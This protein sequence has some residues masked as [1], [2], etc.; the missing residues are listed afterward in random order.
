MP[1]WIPN[2]QLQIRSHA[3]GALQDCEHEQDG[4][5]GNQVG[6][7]DG[8]V[9]VSPGHTRVKNTAQHSASPVFLATAHF[10]VLPS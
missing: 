3:A 5:E 10:L 2:S 4:P 6:R 7:A 9:T 1:T 8:S